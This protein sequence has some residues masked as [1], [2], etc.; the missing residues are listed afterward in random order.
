[1]EEF[2][3]AQYAFNRLYPALAIEMDEIVWDKALFIAIEHDEVHAV[4]YIL[5]RF[6]GATQWTNDIGDKA[7]HHSIRHGAFSAFCDVIDYS[8]EI[9]TRTSAGLTPVQVARVTNQKCIGEM[10]KILAKVNANFD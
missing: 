5:K 7:I 8:A 1:M 9:D 10:L 6:A 2:R 3:Q 4:R